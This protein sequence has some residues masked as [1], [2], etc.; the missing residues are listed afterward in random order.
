MLA[1][2]ILRAV[3]QLLREG[4]L[5]L[6]QR[7][8]VLLSRGA[9]LLLDRIPVEELAVLVGDGQVGL[10]ATPLDLLPVVRR[11][12]GIHRRLRPEHALQRTNAAS[13][14]GF[15]FGGGGR[16]GRWRLHLLTQLL[17]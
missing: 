1:D 16:R 10:E 2:T 12:D 3:V 13:D 8:C 5:E 6:Q 14:R 17:P 7:L 4:R 11:L 9:Q 15:G